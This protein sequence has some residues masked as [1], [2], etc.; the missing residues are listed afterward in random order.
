LRMEQYFTPTRR[1]QEDPTAA[2]AH[3]GYTE[4]ELT[5][6]SMEAFMNHRW[7]W[8]DFRAFVTG[9]EG[10][11]WIAKDTLIRA[12]KGN[13]MM[14]NELHFHFVAQR[15]QFKLNSGE[16]H[17]LVPAKRSS[18]ISSSLKDGASSLFWNAVT[19]SN[20]YKLS[21]SHQCSQ[22]SM[23]ICLVPTFFQVWASPSLELLKF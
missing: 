6:D 10:E 22:F 19:T 21:L 9:D 23:R 13:A 1:L 2:P 14:G 16:T 11:M 3:H 5:A 18:H 17:V 4:A 12:E 7:D 20:G 15:A 8:S